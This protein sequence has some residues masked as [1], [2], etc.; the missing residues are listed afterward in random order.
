MNI[1]GKILAGQRP[2]R[3][4]AEM[5]FS[6]RYALPRDAEHHPTAKSLRSESPPSGGLR[7]TLKEKK[8]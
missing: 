1:T 2:S 5:G 7:S 4:Q 6:A 3:V 8:L